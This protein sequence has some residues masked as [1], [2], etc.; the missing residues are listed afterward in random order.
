MELLDKDC[1]I[2]EQ[3]IQELRMGLAALVQQEEQLRMQQQTIRSQLAAGIKP[4]ESLSLPNF[5]GQQTIGHE[6]QDAHT[7]H[8]M[9]LQ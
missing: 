5:L 7:M 9:V 8:Q 2:A 3:R 4:D 6:A 1:L